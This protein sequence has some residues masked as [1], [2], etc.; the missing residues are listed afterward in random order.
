MPGAKHAKTVMTIVAVVVIAGLIG[1]MMLGT[2]VVP[3]R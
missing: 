2:A 3:Q 1:A